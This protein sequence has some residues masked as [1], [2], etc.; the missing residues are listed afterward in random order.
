MLIY[1]GKSSEHDVSLASARNVFAA[2]D[3]TR[4]DITTCLVDREGRWWLVDTV[5][6]FHAGSP[7]LLPVLGQAKFIT[8][9]DH[10]IIQPDVLLPMLHGKNGEDGT[11]QGLA[12]LLGIPYVG[13]SV[14]AAAVTMDKDMTKRLLE[15]EGIPVVPWRSWRVHDKQPDYEAVSAALGSDIFVKPASAGSS[16][17]VSHITSE[18][19]WEA[20]LS[21]AA[22]NSE[23]VLLESTIKGREIEVA[24]LGNT[25]PRASTPGEVVP[26]QDFY[27]FDD[28]YDPESTAE[29]KIPADLS[30]DI[31]AKLEDYALRAYAVT[32]CR[33]LARVDFF[34]TDSGEIY[35]NE[36]N[37]IPGFTNISMYPK[38]WRHEGIGY[39]Q[40]I[41]RLITLA[42]QGDAI[43]KSS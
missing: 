31:R 21:L 8:L 3:N 20:V 11:V 28:K 4:Y 34:V 40:L 6:D 33:G 7:Q 38:L 42:L 30:A 23:I 29:V 43:L 16:V 13:P 26:G 2:L 37:S 39:P 27:S 24:I 1:G 15:H 36:I 19:D 10:K 32:E 9:P 41:E 35:L 18:Q 5:G 25:N 22:K 12:E 14:L 17:G